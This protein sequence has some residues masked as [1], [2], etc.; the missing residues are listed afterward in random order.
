MAWVPSQQG[1]RLG[2][3]VLG[4]GQNPDI[5][6]LYYMAF[7]SPV[8]GGIRVSMVNMYARIWRYPQTPNPPS[9]VT[10]QP[11]VHLVLDVQEA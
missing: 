3:H 5:A 2:V 10:L 4:T 8:A 7:V 6:E 11:S 9:P 1:M